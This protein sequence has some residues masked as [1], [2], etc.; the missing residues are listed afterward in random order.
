VE[1]ALAAVLEGVDQAPG[2]RF[3]EAEE[4]FRAVTLEEEFP[5]FLTIAAYA[6]YLVEQ[7]AAMA[8]A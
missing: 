4:L 6:R 5:T 3:A 2:T 8:A 1:S 7:P